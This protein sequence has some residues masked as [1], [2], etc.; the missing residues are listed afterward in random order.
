MER[1][2]TKLQAGQE[3]E[4]LL[5]VQ[6]VEKA[7]ASN[8]SH[9]EK[10]KVRDTEGNDAMVFNWNE[11]F[12]APLPAVI[13]AKIHTKLV[14]EM[15]NYNMSTY[16]PDNSVPKSEFLPKPTINV[17]EYWHELIEHAN[18]LPPEL[19]RLVELVLMD[20]Q[21]KFLSYP[22]TSSKS[23]ARRCGILEAT[24]KLTKMTADACCTLP[25]IDR[26]LSITS[27]ILYYVGY[28]EC[29]NDAFLATPEE[30]LIGAGVSAHTKVISQAE[31]VK[32]ELKDDNLQH[33][34]ETVKCISHILLSRYKGINT[35]I[36]EAMLL[37][38]L[39]AIIT[40]IDYMISATAATEPG[41]ISS[42]SGLGKLYRR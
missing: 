23:F 21:K 37:R 32:K 29:I 3:G 35:A 13:Y 26:N 10:L 41:K 31:N 34:C 20:D 15:N 1:N 22:L 25:T 38:H 24:L 27:A 19:R 7:V 33:F 11:P 42:V 39:D 9:Y 2:I 17:K 5:L 28:I 18:Q 40:D 16:Q 30:I 8:G 14:K 6:E 4:I 36:P 12:A